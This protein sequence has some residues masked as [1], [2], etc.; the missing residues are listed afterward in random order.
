YPHKTSYRRLQPR[1]ALADVWRGEARDALFLYIHVPFCEMRCGVCNLFTRA[2][3]PTEQVGAYLRQVRRQAEQVARALDGSG[4]RARYA[5]A[6]FG[7]GTPTYVSLSHLPHVARVV[8]QTNLAV[9][10][11]WLADADARTA[12]LW[13]TYH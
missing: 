5:R 4:E 12:A 1:P 2:H 8:I 7:G 11:D 9:R 13:A 10:V 6:A 3:A